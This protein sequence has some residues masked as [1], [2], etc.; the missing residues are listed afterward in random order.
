MEI[1]RIFHKKA[2]ATEQTTQQNPKDSNSLE[3]GQRMSSHPWLIVLLVT[4]LLSGLWFFVWYQINYEYNRVIERAS[5]DTMNLTI[6]FEEYVRRIVIDADKDL[7]RIKRVYE[8]DGIA[9]PILVE[10]VK[11]AANDPVRNQVTVI[12]EHGIAVV[13]FLEKDIGSDG[14]DRE[15]FQIHSNIDTEKIYIGKTIFDRNSGVDTIPVSRRINKPDGSF[16]GVVVLGLQI[17][18]FADYYKMIDLGSD[19]T[20]S[21]IGKDGIVRAR[22]GNSKLSFNQDVR[23]SNLWKYVVSSPYGTIVGNNYLDKSA[24]L[25]SYRVMED[26]PLV[27]T[28]GES[29]QMALADFTERKQ[30]YLLGGSLVSL[31]ILIILGLLVD[32]VTKERSLNMKL[33]ILVDEKTQ[34]L[35]AQYA[36]VQKREDELFQ[37]NCNLIEKNVAVQTEKDRLTALINSMND[38]VWFTDIENKITLVNQMCILEFGIGSGATSTVELASSL[39]V[40]RP[41]GELRPTEEAPP[42]RALQGEVVRNQQEIVRSPVNGKLRYREVNANP[43]RDARGD[44]IGSVSVVRDVTDRKTMEDELKSHRDNLQTIVEEKMQ[45]IK[46]IEAKMTVILESISDPFYVLDKEW[47]LTYINKEAAQAGIQLCQTHIGQNI[48]EIYPELIGSE[49]WQKY[50]EACATTTPIHK[51]FKGLIGERIFDTHIYPY[52]DGLFVYCRDVTE[53]KKYE[54]D[55][56]RL[57]KLNIIGQMA[58][59]IGHEVRNPMTTVRGYLQWYAKK[60]GFLAYRESFALMIEEL[61][62]ANCIITDFLSLAKD[63]AVNLILTDLNTIIRSAFPLLRAD[64]LRRGNDIEL[65]LQDVVEVFVDTKEMRQCILNLVGNGMDSMPDGGKVTIST[66]QVGNQIVMTVRDR[67]M[68]IS[69]EIKD[70]IGIPFFTTKENGIGLGLPV[71]YQIAQR[72]EATIEVETGPEGTAFHFIFNQKKE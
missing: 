64:A 20:I 38:E 65:E 8:R 46:E 55:L 66:A 58:A 42:L 19:S 49:R 68:G 13:S 53:Q 43:V 41:D 48:W 29:T 67:G 5:R 52:A 50:Y 3:L 2:I 24:R 71:C 61:D 37:V 1:L 11:D 36:M 63:K 18:Y 69:P 60:D 70:K 44:I 62:R 35:R 26:Y 28:I 51:I 27:V 31:F 21:L 16:G 34:E 14:E 45:K 30:S 40:L 57:D 39:E 6:A 15:Y 17:K 25:A 56:L 47:R 22:R 4:C 10:Y 54:T 12:N 23:D 33:A 7:S 72:H 59:S 9:N 32:R